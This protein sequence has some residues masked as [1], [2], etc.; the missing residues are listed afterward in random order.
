MVVGTAK[1][2]IVTEHGRRVLSLLEST[3]P[4]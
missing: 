3:V 1:Y 4:N 2:Y